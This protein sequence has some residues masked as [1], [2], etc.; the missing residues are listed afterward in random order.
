M[1]GDEASD[2]TNGTRVLTRASALNLASSAPPLTVDRNPLTVSPIKSPYPMTAIPV[3]AAGFFHFTDLYLMDGTYYV[4]VEDPTVE[5]LPE[6]RQIL[7]TGIAPTA[8]N[9]PEREPTRREMR[10]LSFEEAKTILGLTPDKEPVLEIPGFTIILNDP[11]PG[12]EWLLFDLWD[13]LWPSMETCL[14]QPAPGYPTS[15]AR[16]RRSPYR[17]LVCIS[18]ASL[19]RMEK[20]RR[21]LR[22]GEN[23]GSLS[24]MVSEESLSS[25]VHLL[26]HSRSTPP[27][28]LHISTVFTH[29][30][31]HD[32]SSTLLQA[33]NS[34][35]AHSDLLP[36]LSLQYHYWA[37]LIFGAWRSYT[38]PSSD[39]MSLPPPQRIV[40]PHSTEKDWRD[41]HGINAYL[42]KLTWPGLS[43]MYENDWVDWEESGRVWRFE[44]VVLVDRSVSLAVDKL[45]ASQIVCMLTFCPSVSRRVTEDPRAVTLDGSSR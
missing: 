23:L 33:P 4:V 1:L 42:T 29:Y 20:F 36:A 38:L 17:V 45:W 30:V 22:S 40:F 13:V 35:S 26:T 3:Q 39:P 27:F 16:E 6:L 41:R 14:S 44:R 31:S 2:G 32:A 37:E 25:L 21:H 8:D 19:P 43:M 34:P 7:S 28:A 11:G 18:I 15:R 5:D 12:C 24:D 10:F 9:E